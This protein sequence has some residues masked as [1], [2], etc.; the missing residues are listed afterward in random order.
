MPEPEDQGLTSQAGALE[1]DWPR[2]I[3]YF[4]GVALAVAFE[5]IEPPLGLFIV[6]IPFIKLLNRPQVPRPAR[7]VAQLL[8]GA[9]KP[10]GGDSDATIR[11]TTPD[12]PVLP[13]E[14][15]PART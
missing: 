6:A 5:L 7:F 15:H 9:A 4:G 13:K 10:L 12:A 14:R 11:L 3:G 2:S 8:D 1:I